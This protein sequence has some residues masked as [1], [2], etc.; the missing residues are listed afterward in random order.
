MGDLLADEYEND[1]FL[2]YYKGG[3]FLFNGNARTGVR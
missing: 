2:S 3:P 1:N